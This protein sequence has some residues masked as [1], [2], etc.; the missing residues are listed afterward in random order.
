MIKRAITAV[1][2][3][4]HDRERRRVQPIVD[5]INAHDARLRDLS[6]EAL[7]AQTDKFR[8]LIRERTSELESQVAA[9]R[10]QKRAAADPAERERLD[11]E[12]G[13]AD[14]RG[15]KEGDVRQ[16]LADTL[17]ESLPEAFATVPAVRRLLLGTKVIGTGQSGEVNHGPY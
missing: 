15:G 10:E 17:D 1:L 13:G 9:L 11:Q 4:R 14:D 7:R 5:A 2:G 3:N 8:A 16:V 6:D 12:I